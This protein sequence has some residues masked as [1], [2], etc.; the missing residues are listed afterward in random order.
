MTRLSAIV[1]AS[2]APPTLGSCLAAIEAAHAG[3]DELVVVDDAPAA[4]AAHARNAGALRATGD[5]LVFVDADV[6]V[7][8]DAF[9][10]IRAA[11]AADPGLAALFGSYDDAPAAPGAV[12]AFRNLLHHHVHQ[13][14]AGPAE[15]FWAGLGAVRRDA[16]EAMGGF[17]TAT[18]PWRAVE[19]VELGMRLTDAGARIVLDPMLLGTHMKGWTLAS[20]VRT[21]LVNRGVPWVVLLLRRGRVPASLNLGWHHRATALCWLA[22]AGALAVRRPRVAAFALGPAAALNR[23]FY[24]LLVRRR[25]P[26]EALLGFG[27]HGLHHL[28]ASAAVPVGVLVHLA[29]A[30]RARHRLAAQRGDYAHEVDQPDGGHQRDRRQAAERA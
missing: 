23:D 13:T 18:P 14:S 21:D 1:P 27:L 22:A 29:G 7:H 30:E 4:G 26:R 16:Y 6:A 2:D 12:S 25:G 15:T 9:A 24:S 10:R 5:V 3:P 19:D 28:T 17:E 11:F 20:M 8:R